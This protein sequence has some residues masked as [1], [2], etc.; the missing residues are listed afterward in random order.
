LSDIS[1]G[2]KTYLRKVT[3]LHCQYCHSN[4]TFN[5][6]KDRKK[7]ICSHRLNYTDI[8]KIEGYSHCQSM[9]PLHKVPSHVG[10]SPTPYHRTEPQWAH[11]YHMFLEDGHTPNGN[12]AF[13]EKLTVQI[14]SRLAK[15]NSHFRGECDMNET[16]P[17]SS[18]VGPM[19]E[20]FRQQNLFVRWQLMQS[21]DPK[22]W[23]NLDPHQWLMVGLLYRERTPDEIR[24]AQKRKK[25]S[26][27]YVDDWEEGDFPR[28]TDPRNL[29]YEFVAVFASLSSLMTSSKAWSCRHVTG[30]C[31]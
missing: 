7:K 31:S 9:P 28:N 12:H 23:R 20:C 18:G 19:F 3:A 27:T 6:A 15:W 17:R 25:D 8:A 2:L 29:P 30:L 16:T 10:Y 26:G 24:K 14:K 4:D 11:V 21:E 22:V 5:F 1:I 13:Y